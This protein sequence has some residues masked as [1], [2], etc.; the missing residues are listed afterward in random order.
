MLTL[1]D[2]REP[3]NQAERRFG[4]LY[5]ANF[6]R[7]LGYAV[8]R[9]NTPE[10]AA[11][12]VSETF[13]VAWRRL[14][15]VPDGPE[16]T[17]WLYATARRVLANQRRGAARRTQLSER[18]RTELEPAIASQA[19]DVAEHDV[20]R[21]AMARLKPADRE[22]LGLVAW[23][24]LGPGE[25]AAVL[26]CSANAAKIRTHRARRRLE[27]ELEQLE[28][29]TP[30]RGHEPRATPIRGDRSTKGAPS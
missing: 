1:M 16:A 30:D 14:D 18:L 24:G 4:A 11:D 3:R 25:L 5:A 29:P 6:S 9:T 7:L 23:E 28:K 26:E 22:L 27:R 12:A 21:R 17:L 13:I 10:D 20:V 8:R 2:V 19:D 15:R